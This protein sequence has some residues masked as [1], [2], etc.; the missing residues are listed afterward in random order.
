VP[1][2]GRLVERLVQ[3]GEL[4]SAHVRRG[5]AQAVL[6]EHRAHLFRR[7]AEVAQRHQH[8]D[9]LVADRGDVAEGA[10]QVRFGGVAQ[11]PELDADA[12]EPPRAGKRLRHRACGDGGGE[13]GAEGLNEFASAHVVAPSETNDERS[14]RPGRRQPEF[15]DR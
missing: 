9:V 7:R 3:R 11:R 1:D 12:T 8:L 14:R 4:A 6:V 15:L 10:I 5:R 13:H 2:H